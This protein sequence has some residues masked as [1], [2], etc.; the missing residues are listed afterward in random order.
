M[1]K[2][3]DTLKVF[4]LKEEG[5]LPSKSYDGDLGYDLFAHE[6][7]TLEQGCQ[8]AVPTG[9]ALEFPPGWGGFIKDRS[10]L[11]IK[12]IYTSAGVIDNGYRGEVRVIVK[13]DSGCDFIFRRGDR[14]AQLV[15]V[16]VTNWVVEESEFHNKKSTD[17]QEGGFGSSG[18]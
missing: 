15:P 17:R 11:A 3:K 16:P 14:V 5:R 1:N 13:N 6:D 9:I 2:K 18:K 4:K 7:V 10:S 8:K 12:G